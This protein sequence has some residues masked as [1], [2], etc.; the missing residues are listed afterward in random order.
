MKNQIKIKN[1]VITGDYASEQE[2]FIDEKANTFKP[3]AINQELS[4]LLG[5]ILT[6][7]DATLVD[8]VQNK[9]VK[10]IIKS[11][12]SDKQNWINELSAPLRMSGGVNIEE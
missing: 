9:A 3:S 7:V 11:R 4:S 6:I 10:D 5:E 8:V 12:F 1:G 2:F